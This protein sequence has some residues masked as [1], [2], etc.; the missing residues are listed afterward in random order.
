M[1][2]SKES[3]EFAIRK[4]T[5]V[6]NLLNW[7]IAPWIGIQSSGPERC[8]YKVSRLLRLFPSPGAWGRQITLHHTLLQ[9]ITHTCPPP[10]L[11]SAWLDSPGLTYHMF[12]SSPIF[13][14]SLALFPAA[15]LIVFCLSFC[16]LTLYLSRLCQLFIKCLLPVPASSL[17]RQL[18]WQCF[19]AL[20]VTYFVHNVSATVSYCKKS[21]WI[22]GQ[23][24]LTTD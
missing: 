23:W 1:A 5:T 22:S 4:Q 15:A 10:S 9:S 18:M 19:P 8:R 17:Q 21:F 16:L 14:C 12:F 3:T 2:N 7:R 20:F 6:S 24:S 13:V 11:T